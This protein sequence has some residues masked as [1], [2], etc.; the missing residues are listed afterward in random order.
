MAKL[1]SCEAGLGRIVMEPATPKKQQAAPQ[2][3][4]LA[5]WERVGEAVDNENFALR[6]FDQ[7]RSSLWELYRFNDQLVSK[8]TLKAGGVRSH[9]TD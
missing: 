7:E 8:L 1:E 6:L 9:K 4:V 3:A 5:H 2:A